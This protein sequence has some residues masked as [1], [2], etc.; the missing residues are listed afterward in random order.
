MIDRFMVNLSL[1]CV[2]ARGGQFWLLDARLSGARM[3]RM[4]GAA[5]RPSPT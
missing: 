5:Q 2:T 1:V 4:V 3:L